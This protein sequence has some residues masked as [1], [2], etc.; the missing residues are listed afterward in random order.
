MFYSRTAPQRIY[1]Y[2]L[3]PHRTAFIIPI[4]TCKNTRTAP[5]LTYFHVLQPHR[6][7]LATFVLGGV[8]ASGSFYYETG[9]GL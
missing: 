7:N 6:T 1:F 4:L 3:Q 9:R 8:G 5:H 2:V